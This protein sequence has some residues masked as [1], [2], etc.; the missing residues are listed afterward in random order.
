MFRIDL[1][2]PKFSSSAFSSL[3]DSATHEIR[4]R[5]QSLPCLI[6]PSNSL[7][8]RV[9]QLKQHR[10]VDP[11]HT[12]LSRHI[13]GVPPQH[14][15][16]EFDG[17]R[18]RLFQFLVKLGQRPLAPL[19]RRNRGLTEIAQRFHLFEEFDIHL[20]MTPLPGDL[21]GNLPGHAAHE[22][23][24]RI[25]P[26]LGGGSPGEM[27]LFHLFRSVRHAGFTAHTAHHLVL[28][29]IENLLRNLRIAKFSGLF[30]GQTTNHS[31]QE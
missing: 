30:F 14:I 24:N 26:V 29:L 3:T 16:D 1:L 2:E 9:P 18:R 28:E 4:R 23:R 11:R 25:Q 27:T 17:D 22:F 7:L 31:A 15:G 13:F 10:L 8:G 20:E 5:L 6:G 21:F 19:Q 12:V